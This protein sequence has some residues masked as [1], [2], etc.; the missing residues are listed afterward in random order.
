V[1]ERPQRQHAERAAR[2]GQCARDRADRAVAAARDDR[3]RAVRESAPR[4]L[5]HLGAVVRQRD[6]RLDAAR[7]E[8]RLDRARGLSVG[9]AA[10][11][12]VDDDLEAF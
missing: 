11:R 8:G 10:R 9:R 2:A 3:A 7:G 4:K 5:R 6:V 12:S 1:V